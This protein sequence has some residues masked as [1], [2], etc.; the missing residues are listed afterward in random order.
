MMTTKSKLV[1]AMIAL[2]VVLLVG[3]LYLFVQPRVDKKNSGYNEV[4]PPSSEIVELVT[5]YLQA[6]ENSVGSNQSSPTSWIDEVKPLVT[7]NWLGALHPKS[8]TTTGNAN[9]EYTIAHENNYT[10]KATVS[11]CI[12]DI[13]QAEPTAS[14]GVIYCDV[15]DSTVLHTSGNTT[16]AENLPFG[17]SRNGPQNPAT[18]KVVKLNG[19]WLIS[20]DNTGE[21]Y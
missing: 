15:T 7:S 8:D 1:G 16:A 5:K 9:A 21:A 17:W 3:V 18:I 14:D 10:V 6:R 2:G 12:W 13:E 20:Y 4:P 19:K 11:D